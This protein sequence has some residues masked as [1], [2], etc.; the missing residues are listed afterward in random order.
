MK[1]HPAEIFLITTKEERARRL[2]DMP[3]M[4]SVLPAPQERLVDRIV[5][6]MVK[7]DER[8]YRS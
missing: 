1:N 2:P 5:G 6:Y 4:V 7:N 3:P 8:A